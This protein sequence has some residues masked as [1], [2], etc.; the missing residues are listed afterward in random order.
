MSS[1]DLKVRVKVGYEGSE[2]LAAVSRALE[3]IASRAERVKQVTSEAATAPIKSVV[4]D[5]A[6][7]DAIEQSKNLDAFAAAAKKARMEGERLAAARTAPRLPIHPDSVSKLKEAAARSRVLRAELARVMNT[8]SGALTGNLARARNSLQQLGSTARATRGQVVGMT[9]GAERGFGQMSRSVSRLTNLLRGWQNI[10]FAIQGAGAVR[11]MVETADTARNLAQRIDQINDQGGGLSVT[12]NDVREAALATHTPLSDMVSLVH[13]VARSSKD[14]ELGQS[15]ILA[16]S[17]TISQANELSGQTAESTQAAMRQF[18]QGLQAGVVRGEEFNSVMEQSPRLSQ[19]MAE[20]LGATIG[21]LRKMAET[22]QLTSRAV[23]GALEDQAEK[24]GREF[25]ALPYTVGRAVTRLRNQMMEGIREL[26]AQ[27]KITERMAQAIGYLADNLDGLG[28]VLKNLALVAA[29]LLG[30]KALGGLGTAFA[31]IVPKVA[32]AVQSLTNMRTAIAALPLAWKFNIAVIGG[33][34]VYKATVAISEF[35]AQ[36]A[37]ADEHLEAFARKRGAALAR[38]RAEGEIA[39]QM[40][41]AYKNVT[42]QTAAE[43]ARMSD[44]ERRLYATRLEGH[45]RYLQ[46]LA[47]EARARAELASLN[48][49]ADSRAAKEAH[50]EWQRHAAALQATRDALRELQASMQAARTD[51]AAFARAASRDL[52][53]AFDSIA[54]AGRKSADQ[55]KEFFSQALAEPLD[56]RGTAALAIALDDLVAQGKVAAGELSATLADAFGELDGNALFALARDVEAAFQGMEISAEQFARVNQAALEAA[57]K[58]FGIDAA[59]ALEQVGA[60]TEDAIE[61]IQALVKV[62][63][64][65]GAEAEKVG[66]ALEQAFSK[67]IDDAPSR[68]AIQRIV[69]EAEKLADIGTIPARS[70]D[71]LREAADA[72]RAAVDNIKPGFQSIEEALESIGVKS[73]RE[74]ERAAENA[75]KVWELVKN[76]PDQ[77]D[78][79]KAEAFQKVEAAVKAANDGMATAWLKSQAAAQ[80]YSIEAEKAGQTTER[81]AARGAASL[82]EMAA[83][84]R[85]AADAIKQADDSGSKMEQRSAQR[86]GGTRSL[87][88][89][90]AAASQYADE[91][92]RAAVETEKWAHYMRVWTSYTHTALMDGRSAADAFVQSLQAIDRQQEALQNKQQAASSLDALKDRLFE[93]DADEEAIAARRAHRARQQ[94]RDQ[95]A[96]LE[97]DI[98][99]AQARGKGEEAAHLQQQ[100]NLLEEQ[101]AL[102]GQI[103]AKEKS[104]RA[105]QKRSREEAERARKKAAEQREAERKKAA[106]EREAERARRQAER[107]AERA[108]REAERRAK[109]AEKSGAADEAN[110]A[111]AIARELLQKTQA[112][113]PVQNVAFNIDSKSLME[114]GTIEELARRMLPLLSDLNRRGV[115]S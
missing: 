9:S 5:E 61:R 64:V 71:R 43:V 10:F 101:L 31:A 103:E 78:G 97:L 94:I 81:A 88:S 82:K 41:L 60:K 20:G 80:G 100:K 58:G 83:A 25:E 106:E 107:E 34:A 110:P 95:Q 55:L 47:D 59:Q 115:Q 109:E 53:A 23:L 49:G 22:G 1:T 3:Q 96:L 98:R 38:M 32:A 45:E 113:Q 92:R 27:Y 99:R 76:A 93:L 26:D 48:D 62:L 52:V 28:A 56:V 72:A 70:L 69:D 13:A 114:R 16:I 108:R 73:Q 15:R 19:A 42:V 30:G 54:A 14:V 90:K 39:A 29:T 77:S 104:K 89:A 74:L 33:A 11:A 37:G 57:F 44:I 40:Q 112:A 87:L 4:S 6:R 111:L 24:I 85:E 105:E 36:L 84:G 65:S 18:I 102:M 2:V 79:V 7:K 86:S 68:A 75:R 63:E 66:A 46:G 91:A 67:A 50:A 17:R 8:P 21:Q 51:T 35:V 12:L